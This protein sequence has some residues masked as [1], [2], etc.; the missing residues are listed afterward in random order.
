VDSVAGLERMRRQ[1]STP[2]RPGIIQSRTTSL[3]A[4]ACC[5]ASQ[6]AAPSQTAATLV[7]K[8]GEGRFQQAPGN[9]LVFGD[10]HFHDTPSL[11]QARRAEHR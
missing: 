2:S 10:E 4:S 3:G 1:T 11:R 7:T 6:A 8:L 5:S 9:R